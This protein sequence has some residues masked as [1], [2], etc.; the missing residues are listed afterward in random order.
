MTYEQFQENDRAD[1][2]A[3][4]PIFNTK[5][6]LPKLKIKTRISGTIEING[7]ETAVNITTTVDVT[8]E[9]YLEA[10][11]QGVLLSI[12]RAILTA[13]ESMDRVAQAPASH[14]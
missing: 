6:M 4:R 1:L 10:I 9:E 2:R 8:N 12:G 5:P 7:E 14:P 3:G 13:T 11:K